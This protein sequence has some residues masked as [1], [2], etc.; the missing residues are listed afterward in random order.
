[1]FG[2]EDPMR[3]WDGASVR[4]RPDRTWE[5][6][7]KLDAHGSLMPESTQKVLPWIGNIH[8]PGNSVMTVRVRYPRSPS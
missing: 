5:P 3:F 7:L 2:A 6:C 8:A 4:Q 1:M